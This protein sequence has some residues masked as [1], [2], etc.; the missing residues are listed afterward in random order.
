LFKST[1]FDRENGFNFG[2]DISSNLISTEEGVDELRKYTALIR[3]VFQVDP[4]TL[5]ESEFK[6][7]A[8]EARFIKDFER[9]TLLTA[10]QQSLGIAFQR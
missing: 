9:R 3:A 4:S 6:K 8:I 1:F 10:L 2:K 5:K 7:L